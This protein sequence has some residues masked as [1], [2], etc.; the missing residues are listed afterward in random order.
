MQGGV[1]GDQTKNLPN[2]RWLALPFEPQSPLHQHWFVAC[3]LVIGHWV[4]F[5]LQIA[6]K[7][8]VPIIC[9]SDRLKNCYNG[10]W[11]K[12][13]KSQKNKISWW[14]SKTF[15]PPRL[16]HY[17]VRYTAL[18]VSSSS[19]LLFASSNQVRKVGFK[20]NGNKGRGVDMASSLQC[21]SLC[22]SAAFCWQSS[23]A[24]TDVSLWHRLPGWKHL[25]YHL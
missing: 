12:F 10:A 7:D 8:S 23:S 18:A 19:V 5:S 25:Q 3:V 6:C 11:S 20:G 17:G 9:F 15:L 13:P 1:V 16:V 22:F 21:C 14:A 2:S 24:E 4:I